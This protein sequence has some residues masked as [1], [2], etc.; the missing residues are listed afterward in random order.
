MTHPERTGLRAGDHSVPLEGV[1]V[2]ATVVGPCVETRITQR[3]RNT[4]ARPLEAVYVFP[5][6]EGAAVCGFTARIDGRVVRGV[7]KE[8][9]EAFE[10]Y[11]DAMAMGHGAYLLDQERPDV[12]TASVGNLEPGAT[13]ELEVRT[14]ALLRPEGTA[15]RL[16]VPTAVAPRYLPARGPEIGQPEEER[17]NPPHWVEVPYGL[18]L[19]VDVDV[20]GLRGLESPSHPIRT[21][22]REGGAR[23]ELSQDDV[24][25]DR[26]FV[27][28][29]DADAGPRALVAREE[30]GTRVA[31]VTFSPTV[32][33]VE[34]GVDVHFVVDCS[35]SMMGR[36]MEEAKKALHL[37]IRA[38]SEGDRFEVI[39]F[40]SRFQTMFGGLRA[41]DEASL[42]EATEYVER[43]DARLGG[44]EILSPLRE[45]LTDGGGVRAHRVLLLTDGQVGNESEVIALARE[46]AGRTRV[47]TFG[48][49]AGASQHLVRGVARASG[50]AAEMIAPG[51]RIEPKVLRTFARLRA[52]P[53]EVSIDWGGLDVE[54][55]PRRLPP[56]FEGDPLTVFGRVRAGAGAEVTLRAGDATFTVPLDLERTE[57]EG[58]VPKLW[59]R[60]RIRELEEGQVATGSSQRRGRSEAKVDLQLVELGQRYGLVSRATSYVAVEERAPDARTTEAAELRRVPVA[61][62]FGAPMPAGVVMRGAPPAPAMAKGM[63]FGAALSAPSKLAQDHPRGS[64]GMMTGGARPAAPTSVRAEPRAD[65]ERLGHGPPLEDR[66]FGAAAPEPTDALFDV[67][68]TQHADGRFEPSDALAVLL[69]PT[70]ADRLEE[71]AE[72]HPPALVATAVLVAWLPVHRAERSAEWTPAVRKAEAWLATQP[73]FDATPLL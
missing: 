51:E 11:D 8:R 52:Q 13:V 64:R 73:A 55:A 40:G 34:G 68:M 65:S 43:M 22:L 7:V 17:V 72:T 49:G 42:A 59:A 5:L 24:A 69:G 60:E 36:S 53:V 61:L 50:G 71:A 30:D 57:V 25:L 67:L 33:T 2:D 54:A 18:T 9:E 35:G 38:L 1:R 15:R 23:V 46:H 31:M 41:F 58:P 66:A 20:P 21:T 19:S 12:F 70:L 14:V 56:A 29:I 16:T 62:T 27:L 37:C 45:A 28:V 47:F 39:A 6:D 3:Y 10:A 32:P 44:T 4:E 26:D 48:I 63:V